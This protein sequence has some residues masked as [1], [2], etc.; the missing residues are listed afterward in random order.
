MSLNSPSVCAALGRTSTPTIEI[1]GARRKASLTILPVRPRAPTMATRSAE[2]GVIG[3]YY[4]LLKLG[5]IEHDALTARR[6]KLY[7]DEGV[8][9]RT[10][11]VKHRTAAKLLVHD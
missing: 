3:S 2:L 5:V 10:A 7:G 4:D 1:S 6:V 9:T 11:H 8:S